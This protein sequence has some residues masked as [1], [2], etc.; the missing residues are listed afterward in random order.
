MTNYITMWPDKK[1][2]VPNNPILGCMDGDGIGQEITSQMR[3]LLDAGVNVVHWN[4]RKINWQQLLLWEEAFA[5]TGLYLPDITVNELR[6]ILVAIK[7]PTNTPLWGGHASV[8]VWLRRE[9]DLGVCRR[10]VVFFPGVKSP[11]LHPENVSMDIFRENTEWSYVGVEFDDEETQKLLAWLTQ[12]FPEKAKKIPFKQNLVSWMDFASEFASKRI[13]RAAVAFAIKNN[14]KSVTVVA[15]PNIKKLVDGRFQ[16]RALEVAHEEFTEYFYT[17]EEAEAIW[18]E[19]ARIKKESGRAAAE[20]FRNSKFRDIWKIEVQ[21]I[22]ADN[23]FQQALIRPEN[24]DVVVAQNLNGDYMSDALAAQVGGL[25][26]A[27]GANI[28]F[29]TGHAVFEATHGTAPDIAGMW[30]ANPTSIDLSAVM[31]MDYIWRHEVAQT[32]MNSIRRTI[33]EGNKT[34]DLWGKLNTRSYTDALIANL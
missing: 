7:W 18:K 2:I 19:Y 27:P 33:G 8:N 22:I 31:M 4:R 21:T 3:R 15:K 20:T 26:I 14:K 34:G 9:L 1:L 5:A 29:E 25:W 10:P 23:F 17:A 11:V 6:K 24:Y 28:N 12:E 30:L 16:K 32:I 13:M